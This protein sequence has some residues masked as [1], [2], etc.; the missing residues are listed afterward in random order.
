MDVDNKNSKLASHGQHTEHLID[1]EE[2][3]AEENV[4]NKG[5]QEIKVGWQN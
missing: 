2:V 4:I 3:R 5:K 1:A